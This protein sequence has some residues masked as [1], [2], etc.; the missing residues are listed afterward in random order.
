V[1]T[2]LR[3][4]YNQRGA[5]LMVVLVTVVVMGLVA[6]LTGSTWKTVMQRAKEEEL[7]FR[8]DQYR[9]AI[10]SYYQAKHGTAAGAFPQNLEALL[11]DPRSLQTVR[12]LRRLYT[13]PMTGGDWLLIKDEG[14]RVKGVKSASDLEP[15][16]QDGFAKVYEKF[17]GAASYSQWEFVYEPP[18]K[19]AKPVPP[20]PAGP[21]KQ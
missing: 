7:L 13:D 15:F 18:A 11:K 6:G 16:K 12:H 21:G 4:L 17:R 1:K 8:G 19:T 5:T 20:P 14:G 2:G 3:P 10:E 9:R